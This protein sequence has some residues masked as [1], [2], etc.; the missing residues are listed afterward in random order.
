MAKDFTK[1]NPA[2]AYIS[3]ANADNNV[4]KNEVAEEKKPKKS[5][6]TDKETKSKR[7]NLVL[8]PSSKK[9]IKK[10]ARMK[11]ISSNEQICRLVEECIKENQDL[12]RK[13]DEIFGDIVD[14][15]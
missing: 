13:H 9:D 12:I 11:G 10:I 6:T 15:E 8:Q 1:K 14:D 5:R 7:F 2:M 4:G 3:S